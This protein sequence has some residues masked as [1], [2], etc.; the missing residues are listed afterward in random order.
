VWDLQT[1]VVAE[2]I[3]KKSWKAAPGG[4]LALIERR[5]DVRSWHLLAERRCKLPVPAS[6]GRT[7]PAN[8]ALAISTVKWP[9]AVLRRPLVAET[10]CLWLVVDHLQMRRRE[11]A[12][13]QRAR[14]AARHDCSRPAPRHERID[15]EPTPTRRPLTY[16]SSAAHAR[17]RVVRAIRNCAITTLPSEARVARDRGRIHRGQRSPRSRGGSAAASSRWT[18]P[19]ARA[20]SPCGFGSAPGR[21]SRPGECSSTIVWVHSANDDVNLP[22]RVPLSAPGRKPGPEP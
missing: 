5:V 3:G 21:Q 2:S 6:I 13:R 14:D 19:D 17:R 18:A 10:V 15:L 22:T 8:A 9:A 7:S 4:H 12:A 11:A 16:G 20:G 1:T